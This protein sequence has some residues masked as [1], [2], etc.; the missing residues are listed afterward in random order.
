MSKDTS[1]VHI[2][3]GCFKIFLTFLQMETFFY[4]TRACFKT[5]L[6]QLHNA[7]CGRSPKTRTAQRTALTELRENIL[8]IVM[9]RWHGWVLKHSL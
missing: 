4:I 7:I 5:A 1:K 8:W 9:Y 2:K 3:R 6:Y